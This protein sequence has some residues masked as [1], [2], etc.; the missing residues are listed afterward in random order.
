VLPL[1][2]AI[3]T[4]WAVDDAISDGDI[5]VPFFVWQRLWTGF[6]VATLA[7]AVYPLW[8]RRRRHA[9]QGGIEGGATSTAKP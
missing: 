7:G 5:V 8:M 1:T 3:V 4:T 6:L 2:N 9:A